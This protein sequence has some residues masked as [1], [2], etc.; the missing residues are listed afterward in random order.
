MDDIHESKYEF[1]A[2]SKNSIILDS[3]TLIPNNTIKKML[4]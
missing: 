4:C 2:L 3:T 1:T